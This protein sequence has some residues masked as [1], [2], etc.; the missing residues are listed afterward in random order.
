MWKGDN[1]VEDKTNYYGEVVDM[2]YCCHKSC[3]KRQNAFI[4]F[5]YITDVDERKPRIGSASF[6]ELKIS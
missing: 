3:Y 4:S 6:K 1:F 2:N 5:K